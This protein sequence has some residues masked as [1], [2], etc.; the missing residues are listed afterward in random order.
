MLT[1]EGLFPHGVSG[2]CLQGGRVSISSLHSFDVCHGGARD[3]AGS[4]FRV[5]LVCVCFVMGFYTVIS[6]AVEWGMVDDGCCGGGLDG[7]VDVVFA[8]LGMFTEHVRGVYGRRHLGDGLPVRQRFSD[9]AG[10]RV[11]VELDDISP[12]VRVKTKKL[13]R[14][15]CLWVYN[16]RLK[17]CTFSHRSSSIAEMSS[18]L[19]ISC[20]VLL[21][22]KQNTAPIQTTPGKH[23]QCEQKSRPHIPHPLPPARSPQSATTRHLGTPHV[24]PREGPLPQPVPESEW[25]ISD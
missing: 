24:H 3:K 17:R 19:I 10:N 5:A 18:P 1:G 12:A 2:L 25:T 15:C 22:L 11:Y 16:L 8:R 13:S 23:E 7:A 6:V 4:W 9:S 21:P 14:A 20:L